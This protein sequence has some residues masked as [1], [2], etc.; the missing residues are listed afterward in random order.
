M[1]RDLTPARQMFLE[2]SMPSP[3]RERRRIEDKDIRFMAV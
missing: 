1:T 3:V 2:S